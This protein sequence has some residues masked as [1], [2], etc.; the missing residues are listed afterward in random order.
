MDCFLMAFTALLR[1]ARKDT[2]SIATALSSIRTLTVPD[3]VRPVSTT[4]AVATSLSVALN[5]AGLWILTSA[6]SIATVA[7]DLIRGWRSE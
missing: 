2:F 5:N 1:F 4:A 3:A 7:A 6:R